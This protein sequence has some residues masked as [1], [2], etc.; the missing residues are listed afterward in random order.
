MRKTLFIIAMV[1]CCILTGCHS[2]TK[3]FGG[4]MTIELEPGQKLEEITWKADDLWILSRPMREDERPET[5]TFYED[6]EWGLF[7]GT[8][9]VV[10]KGGTK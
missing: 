9:T 3:N 10:E 1:V 2:T 6:S 4:S 5:H 8:V 7:E